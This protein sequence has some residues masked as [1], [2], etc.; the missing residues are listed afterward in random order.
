VA[1]N[2]SS[3]SVTAIAAG[4][5]RPER[6]VG[7]HFFNPP[8]RMPLVEVIAGA[9]TSPHAIELAR[10]TA[11]AMGRTPILTRDG[12]G[13]V[14]N[15]VARPFYTE[16]LRIVDE[17]L[18]TPE[19]VDGICR[20]GG[21]RMG[22]FEL[23]D[24]V[25]LDTGLAV[26]ESFAR[27]SLGEPRWKPSHTQR[28]LVA[29]GRLGRKTGR[30]FHSYGAGDAAAAGLAV[31]ASDPPRVSLPGRGSDA[32]ALGERARSAGVA[33]VD[34]APDLAVVFD[35]A[36]LARVPESAP[37]A[38]SCAHASL[39]AAQRPGSVG[40][41]LL[42]PIEHASVLELTRLP[43]SDDDACRAAQA[44]GQ[45][46]GLE[47]VWV[48]DGPGLV[49]GRIVAQLVNEG[50][51]AVGEGLA[52]PEDVD[53]ATTLGFNHPHG[54]IAWGERI[55]WTAVRDRLDG[56]WNERREERYRVAP[57]LQRAAWCETSVRQ[58]V[59]RGAARGVWG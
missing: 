41:D 39:A 34:E 31:P 3:L 9:E 17:G 48:D 40:F 53:L 5:P 47:A 54:P 7:M 44:L 2:T 27:Q 16:A 22:P 21:F 4:L 26:A 38:I 36:E 24:L 49:L 6:V 13:F 8:P 15:R 52:A 58:L 37:V 10:Q 50:C 19:V 18:A 33:I 28:R 30:G 14:A 59:P 23:M 42:S 25:G 32:I 12:I 11:R 55:G 1:T 20:A 57:L 51:F 35:R 46:L 43:R 45:A 29:A 56:L